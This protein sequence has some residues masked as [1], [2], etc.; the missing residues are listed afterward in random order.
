[1]KKI[2]SITIL[3]VV[4][5][6]IASLQAQT[7]ATRPTA[8]PTPTASQRPRPVPNQ[9]DAA[10]FDLSDFGVS[11]QT[12][13]RL[14]IMMAALEAAGFNALPPGVEPSAFRAQV[15]KDLAGLDPDLRSRLRTF[16]ER[17]KLPAPATAA[18]QAARYVSLAFA[19]GPPPL[20]EAPPRSE[21]L[22]GSLLEVLDFAPLVREFY[23]RSNIEESLPVYTRAYQAETDLLRQPTAEMI[24]DVLSYLHTRPIAYSLERVQVKPLTTPKKNAPKTYSTRERPRHFYIVSDLLGAP[25]AINFRVIGDEYFAVLPQGTDP[26]SSELRRGY[27]QYIVDPLSLKFNRDIAARRE[28]IKLI[29]SA[30]EKAGAVISPDIFLAVSR[31]LVAAADA[32]YEE[33]RRLL[34]LRQVARVRLGDA[35]DDPA[36][37]AIAKELQANTQ[38]VEDETIA[39]LADDYEKGAILAFYFADQ[40]KGIEVSGFDVAGFFG[41][42]IASFDPVRETNRLSENAGT[43]ERAMAARRARLAARHSEI[44]PPIYTEAEA[45]K[46]AVLVK[47][48]GEIEQTL[49]SKDYNNAEARLKD[50]LRDYSREPRIF[51]ALA[52]T[53][54][55]AAADAIDEDVQA[56]RL[57]RAL[58][59]YR[60]AIEASSP[61]T[62]RAIIS[63]AHEAMGRIH[64]FLEHA[65]D[66]AKEFD[67]AI[68]MGEVPGGA[69]KDALEGK[70]KLGAP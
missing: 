20:L 42:M 29:I 56:E 41:D 65:A 11:F 70:R 62:D 60:L 4:A 55:L 43:R 49:R 14:I 58:G 34:Y 13:P 63:R 40:L 8:S 27:L 18:D 7:G 53:A 35:K 32:R 25:G 64:A 68:R 67:E 47:T 48:L 30:R 3:L 9:P 24:R 2:I 1:M 21:E 22:P 52:Q 26:S 50:L 44:G 66:A 31:S 23:R 45:A 39:R 6:S 37:Q 61:E 15:R 16:Y 12:E 10:G 38:A 59:N 17:N 69:F 51:F 54:S 36:R 46:A 28:Q 57:N 33:A 5:G 19:L